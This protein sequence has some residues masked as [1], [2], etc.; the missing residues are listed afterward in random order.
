MFAGIE[1]K[2]IGM[3]KVWSVVCERRRGSGWCGDGEDVVKGEVGVADVGEMKLTVEYGVGER[4]W[5]W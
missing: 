5:C 4:C 2:R 1:A 3:G